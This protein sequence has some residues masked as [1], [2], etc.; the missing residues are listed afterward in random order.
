MVIVVIV[1]S[2]SGC[3]VNAP[4]GPT[5]SSSPAG[6]DAPQTSNPSED[7]TGPG[8]STPADELEPLTDLEEALA[9]TWRRYHVKNSGYSSEYSYYEY[10]SFNENRT[11]CRWKYG[12]KSSSSSTDEVFESSDYPDWRI[13]EELSGAGAAFRV[14][15]EGRGLDYVFDFARN[16][17]YPA[18][19]ETLVFGPTTDGKSCVYRG[20]AS[21]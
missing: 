1:A 18:G 20:G 7:P 3:V 14:V 16:I 8:T 5:R 17:V 19:F 11:A 10:V 9:G 21:Y 2:M 15:V 12:E 6:P 13:A 4:E